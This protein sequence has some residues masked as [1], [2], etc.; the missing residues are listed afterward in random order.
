[1]RRTDLMDNRP[2]LIQL[3]RKTFDELFGNQPGKA[4]RAFHPAKLLD[5]NRQR[6][7][8]AKFI[9]LGRQAVNILTVFIDLP[10]RLFDLFQKLHRLAGAHDFGIVACGHFNPRTEQPAGGLAR[11]RLEER[12][13]PIEPIHALFQIARPTEFALKLRPFLRDHRA[14]GVQHLHRP[15]LLKRLQQRLRL[16]AV[17]HDHHFFHCGNCHLHI[18]I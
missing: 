14:L 15:G 18:P 17:G 9:Y 8:R 1:M 16:A 13:R 10:G 2:Q 5:R 11:I 12:N 3:C 4:D 7:P 6:R